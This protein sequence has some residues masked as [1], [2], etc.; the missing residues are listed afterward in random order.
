MEC[1]GKTGHNIEYVLKLAEWARATLPE[2]KDEHL[3]GLEE[4]IRRKAEEKGLVLDNLMNK[5]MA[6]TD[7]MFLQSFSL[8]F[9]PW[10][11]LKKSLDKK[12]WD[13]LREKLDGGGCDGDPFS[14]TQRQ[15]DKFREVFAKYDKDGDGMITCEEFVTLMKPCSKQAMSKDE[16]TAL[17]GIIDL[18]GDGCVSFGEFLSVMTERMRRVEGKGTRGAFS[19]FDR[20]GN[21]LIS[22]GELGNAM[23][24]LGKELSQEEVRD[25]IKMADAD[26]DKQI[27]YEE[28]VTMMALVN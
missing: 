1:F 7:L 23:N 6:A 4:I 11:A 16:L 15:V 10:S 8:E 20:D 28:F 14:P 12:S 26:G 18:D 13:T 3:Y 19:L 25:M 2:V 24:T 22:A 21:G 9:A 17:I 27:C 5:D